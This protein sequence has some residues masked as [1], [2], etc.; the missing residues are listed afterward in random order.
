MNPYFL[1]AIADR[2]TRR[3]KRAKD[4]RGE[5]RIAEGE[6]RGFAGGTFADGVCGLR[7][8]GV[9]ARADHRRISVTA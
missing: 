3:T 1:S 4:G 9:A 8:Q 2:S 5:Q 6:A 7:S